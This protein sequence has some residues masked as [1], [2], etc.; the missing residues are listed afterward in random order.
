MRTAVSPPRARSRRAASE[1]ATASMKP[2]PKAVRSGSRA[3]LAGPH[4]TRARR[5]RC[6]RPRRAE[7]D[8]GH[9]P[10][11]PDAPARA[12]PA[13]SARA[14]RGRLRRSQDLPIA[15]GRANSEFGEFGPPC[16]STNVEDWALE[17]RMA[18][19]ATGREVVGLAHALRSARQ[20]RAGGTGRDQVIPCAATAHASAWRVGQKIVLVPNEP[21]TRS[22]SVRDEPPH[23][24]LGEA[25]P[26]LAATNRHRAGR[27]HARQAS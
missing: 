3:S 17:E 11:S 25:R 10:R 15:R 13:C 24:L 14:G 21:V 23:H 18:R 5:R 12:P 20:A 26:D 7:E 4:A 19:R 1:T 27:G 22:V 8:R 2:A 16:E 6:S 9:I